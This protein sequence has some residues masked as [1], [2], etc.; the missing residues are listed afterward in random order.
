MSTTAKIEITNRD[1]VGA[2]RDFLRLL[3]EKE[4]VKGVLVPMHMP[5]GGL[6]MPTLVADPAELQRVDPFAPSFPLNAAALVAK[7]TRGAA[8]GHVAAVLRPCEIRAF[9]ELA[10]LNQGSV[11]NV[12]LIGVECHGAFSNREYHGFVKGRDPLAATAAF[13]EEAL[14]GNG[15]AGAAQGIIDGHALAGACRACEH[16]VPHMADLAVGLVGLNPDA[17]LPLI[18]QTPRGERALSRLKLPEMAEDPGRPK[19]MEALSAARVAKRDAMFAETAAAT[20]SIQK[21]AEFLSNCINCYN[22]RVACPVCYCRECVFVTNV[23]D[24]KPWQYM[25]WAKKQG[26]LKMPTDTVFYHMTR[27]AHMSL[28][29]VGCGQCSNACPNDVPVMEL[30][31]LV[32]SRTQKAFEYEPGGSLDQP[33]PLTVFHEKEVFAVA[34]GE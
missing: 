31:R 34:E 30:F 24:H 18:S 2:M 26:L 32:A 14:K 10:K 8:E 22:C 9:R 3:L 17:G 25:G 6:A 11:D 5:G 23:F 21:L 20:D 33:P 27:M 12:L 4:D 19:A 7:L 13:L 28:S 1:V 29:C 15:G 16:F